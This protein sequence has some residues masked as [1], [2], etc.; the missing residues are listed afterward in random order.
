MPEIAAVF[1]DGRTAARREVSIRIGPGGLDIVFN[2]DVLESWAGADLRLVPEPAGEASVR[3][4]NTANDMARLIVADPGFRAELLR[5]FP[6]IADRHRDTRSV[7]RRTAMWGAGLVAVAMIVLATIQYLPVFGAKLVPLSWEEKVGQQTVDQIIGALSGDENRSGRC[8]RTAGRA[9]LER[10]TAR[11]S[12]EIDS[13]YNLRV[14]VADISVANAFAVPGGQVVLFRGL[15]K[16][17]DSADAVAGVLAHEFAHVIH[18]HPTQSVLRSAGLSM[19]LDL[20]TGN[21]AG[22]DVISGAGKI[23]IGASYS[24]EAEA[25]ADAT[26]VEIMTRAGIS[27]EGLEAFFRRLAEKEEALG[28]KIGSLLAVISSHPRSA[29][30]AG[31]V[32]NRKNTD[33]R[34]ALTDREWQALKEICDRD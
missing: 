29:A 14:T 3:L 9:A 11:L 27:T 31:A 10:L 18:R 16:L 1:Y 32:A 34:P 30:R 6:D 12:A 15:F 19:L 5:R 4:T 13:P 25:G 20:L 22:G 17:A 21:M 26:A 24:R 33:A 28:G 23:I 7:L 8:T 2:G